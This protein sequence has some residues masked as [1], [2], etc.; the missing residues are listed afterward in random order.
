M[1]DQNN[2]RRQQAG[3]VHRLHSPMTRRH[4]LLGVLMGITVLVLSA[5]CE[6]KKQTPAAAPP[7]EVT[8]V[9]VTQADVPIYSEWIGTTDGLVNAK[10]RAQVSGYLARQ[11]YKEGTTVKKGD[12]L[13][14][15]DPRPF[16]AALDQAVAQLTMAKARLGKTELDVKRY[17]PLARESAI[18]QQELDDAVQA[19]LAAKGGVQSAEAAVEQARLNLDFT[20]IVSPIDGIAGTSIVQLGD[21]VGPSTT[22]E[23]TTVST[24]NPIKVHF[25]ISEREYMEA[26]QGKEQTGRKQGDAGDIVLELILAD[27]SVF[28]QQGKLYFADR[29]VDVKTGTIRVAALFPN[30]G[31]LLRPGQ[32]ARVR[33]LTET[34]QNALLVPQRSITELQG[35]FQVAVV[36]PDNKVTIRNVKA[37]AR[38]G[39]Q[40]VIDE[41]LKP[42]ERVVM[43][44]VQK[45]REG[46]MV[47]PKPAVADSQ[48]GSGMSP[49]PE[50]KPAP[51]PGAKN[52]SENPPKSPFM[53]G[54]L[55]S[56][57]SAKRGL[58]SPPFG[59][60]G[61]GG[62]L[63]LSDRQELNLQTATRKV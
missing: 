13:F 6:E 37:G 59:R 40:W 2:L 14:E 25:P 17:T 38:V 56:A 39:S 31:N 21:L 10:I 20:R 18:S 55:S 61:S 28:P 46:Q 9:Q 35:G 7:P 51:G 41:G 22:S 63:E 23:L 58:A 5:G 16:K 42:G 4:R 57:S 48:P 26:V 54:G 30:P 62:I 12:L 52:L 27:G 19:N 45:V 50:K 47:T 29:Q 44:G 1:Q 34:R 11:A 32:F 43:E 8:V 53:E 15:I 36:G 24:V 33:A 3:G 60:G 49:S